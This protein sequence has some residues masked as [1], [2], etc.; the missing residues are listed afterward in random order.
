MAFDMNPLNYLF[1]SIAIGLILAF[2]EEAVYYC[3]RLGLGMRIQALNAYLFAKA[4]IMHWQIC[5]ELGKMGVASPPFR[6]IPIWN[7][8]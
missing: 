1:Y 5:R 3:Y 7:R 8:S 4:W 6:F 2:Q